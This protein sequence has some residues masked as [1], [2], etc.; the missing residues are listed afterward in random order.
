MAENPFEKLESLVVHLMRESKISGMSVA[1]V[2]DG[3]SV[4]ARGFGARNREKNLPMTPDTLWTIA[5]ISKSFCA[6]AIM[7]QVEKEKSTCM[8]L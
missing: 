7:Q 3:H 4:F 6:M 2:K 5:S 8:L 1:V